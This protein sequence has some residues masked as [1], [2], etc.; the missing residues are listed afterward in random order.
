[1]KVGLHYEMARPELDDHLL[2]SETLDQIV[3]ADQMGFDYVWLVEHHF[4]TGFS[5]SACPDIVYGA[6][7]QR[8]ERIRLGLGVV[9]LPYHH[10]IQVAERVATLDHL[11]EGRVDMGTGRSAPYEL[12]GMGIDPIESREMWEESLTMIPR[13]WES[14]WFEWKGKYWSV[15]SRQ[16][17]PKPYQDPH[18][19]IWVAALQSATYEIAAQKGLGVLAMGASDPSVLE[20]YVRA[21]HE[22]VRKA[23]PVGSAINAQWASQTIG[24]CTE[25]NREGRDLGAL[26][27][28]SFFAPDRPYARGQKDI[29]SRLLK[30][31]GGI[32]KH[33]EQ[34]FIRSGTAEEAGEKP[35]TEVT[36]FI[37]GA[38]WDRLDPDTLCDRAVII[39]GDPDSC[40]EALKKHEAA[41]VD[42]VLIS[43]QTE[44]VTHDVVM[45]SIELFGKYVVPEFKETQPLEALT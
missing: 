31:W 5:G 14:D 1:M 40:V 8:T 25:D 43:M 16:V 38:I 28:K 32:P 45:K 19:P 42:Q 11:A 4:L 9:V 17:L 13:I 15:P 26:S 37:A 30:Q 18:P 44:T 36:N 29:Y 41:G 6:L 12:T 7:S 33:L 23:T 27:I 10:P 2:F 39:A 3:L 20:P 24:I 35:E 22:G 21:Y 34:E